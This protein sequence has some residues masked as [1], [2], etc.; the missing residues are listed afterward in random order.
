MT[1]EDI[2]NCIY[3]IPSFSSIYR[4]PAQPSHYPAKWWIRQRMFAK[5]PN[6]LSQCFSNQEPQ[7][8]VP[9]GGVWCSRYNIFQWRIRGKPMIFQPNR[10]SIQIL[11]RFP[12][13][14]CTKYRNYPFVLLYGAH[15][16]IWVAL[17]PGFLVAQGVRFSL[18]G[19][20]YDHPITLHLEANGQTI[21]YTTDGSTP[22]P[23]GQ[24]YNRPLSLQR[25]QVVRAIACL[26]GRCTAEKA[27]SY[28]LFEP[29]SSFLTVSVAVPPDALFNPE[30]GLYREGWFAS[31]DT[32]KKP[33]ANFWSKKELLSH[34]EIFDA[35][36]QPVFNKN[37]GFRLFGGMSRLFCPEIIFY[38]GKGSIW[39]KT[40]QLSH[41]WGGW[42]GKIQIACIRNGGSDW[43]KSHFRD[44]LMSSLLDGWDLEKQDHQPA[45][46]YLN[47]QYW[48]VLIP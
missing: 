14:F 13:L 41:I 36:E 26:S 20:W 29:K 48:G 30:Y 15:I 39:K 23:G 12:M 11:N 45:H 17:S 42:S 43:G 2:D 46:V 19:G 9:I 44:A 25:T 7:R 31:N 38:H 18:E 32:W 34:I 3:D 22:R 10:C 28:F 35:E 4:I 21:Y 40:H 6:F 5:E 1:V 24:V 27:N 33:G 16:F 8:E 37:V 47:G